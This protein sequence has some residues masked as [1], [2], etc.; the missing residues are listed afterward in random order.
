MLS[1]AMNFCTT[2]LTRS[3]PSFPCMLDPLVEPGRS[4]SSSKS[5]TK[6]ENGRVVY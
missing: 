2:L 6:S 5:P 4:R 3:R 1:F